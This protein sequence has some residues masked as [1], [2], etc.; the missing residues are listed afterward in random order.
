MI[1]ATVAIWNE[2]KEMTD[3]NVETSSTEVTIVS[4]NGDIV[5]PIQ[6]EAAS[7]VEESVKQ[8]ST[9]LFRTINETTR[10]ILGR[11]LSEIDMMNF[12]DFTKV[13]DRDIKMVPYRGHTL[14]IK[15]INEIINSYQNSNRELLGLLV[16]DE[17]NSNYVIN[18]THPIVTF[19]LSINV[20]ELPERGKIVVYEQAQYLPRRYIYHSD[21]RNIEIDDISVIFARYYR[22]CN[23]KKFTKKI[24]NASQDY[25]EKII[26]A[27]ANNIVFH[28]KPRK[29]NANVFHPPASVS[30]ILPID[31]SMP[32]YYV[33]LTPDD[34]VIQDTQTFYIPLQILGGNVVTPYVGDVYINTSA[35]RALLTQSTTGNINITINHKPQYEYEEL[36]KVCTGEY[37]NAS[38]RGMQT[39]SKINTSSLYTRYFVNLH[40]IDIMKGGIEVARRIL[41]LKIK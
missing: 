18:V 20:F 39:L 30:S 5:L 6:S 16:I 35:G 38:F 25:W 2:F 17:S 13:F 40:E 23:E 4:N 15:L 19:L 32:P 37:S 22:I 24:Q 34:N 21:G 14:G 31:N 11:S 41:N 8:A 26:Q 29:Y 27:I 3:I 36:N 1:N 33:K 7:G 10:K 9:E 12:E 28:S